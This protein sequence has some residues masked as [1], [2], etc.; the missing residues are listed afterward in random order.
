MTR[1]MLK[2]TWL[3]PVLLTLALWAPAASAVYADDARGATDADIARMGGTEA[4][5]GTSASADPALTTGAPGLGATVV[6]VFIAL[7]VVFGLMTAILWAAKRW[8]PRSMQTQLRGGAIDILATRPLG[9]RR[10]LVLVKAREKTLLLGITPQAIQCLA[11]LEDETV[12]SEAADAVGLPDDAF[13]PRPPK[14]FGEQ[15]R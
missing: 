15:A 14:P 2:I 4:T 7:G 11:E 9:Q 5:R 6:R 12:W 13:A 3:L 8:L 1:L 10:S